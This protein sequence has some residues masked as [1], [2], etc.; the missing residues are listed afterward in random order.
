MKKIIYII[1][2]LA[3]I[4]GGVF[5]WFYFS[6]KSGV[7]NISENKNVAVSLP[8]PVKTASPLPSSYSIAD[9]FPKTDTISIGTENGA[10]EVK[11]FYKNIVDTEEGSAIL[12][13]N[14]NY[15]ISYD[16]NTSIFYIHFRNALVPQSKAETE[17][18]TLLGIVQHDACRLNVLVFQVGQ[19]NGSGLSFCTNG[20]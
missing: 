20:K 12:V 5:A 15:Q 19:I 7:R 17:L 11:N 4:A 10:V 18:L 8:A 6:Q 1:I 9:T 14:I 16:R 2:I 3:V 13:D